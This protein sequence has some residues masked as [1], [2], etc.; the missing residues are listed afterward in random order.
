MDV[1]DEHI[2]RRAGL[3]VNS[4][5]ERFLFVWLLSAM[6]IGYVLSVHLSMLSGAIVALF[7]YMTFVTALGT[8]LRDFVYVFA[9]PQKLVVMFLLI[10]LVLPLLAF[11]VAH[12]WL[13]SE[14]MYMVGVVLGSSIPVGVT[15]IM[16]TGLAGGDLPLALAIVSVDTMLSP[17]TLPLTIR[18]IFGRAVGMPFWT[19]FWGL[20]WMVVIPTIAGM[21][22]NEWSRG[23]IKPLLQP[24]A[25]PTSK[26]SLL[27]VVAINVAIVAPE[28]THGGH[29]AMLLIT[30][31]IM[32]AM[33]YGVGYFVSRMMRAEN[34]TRVTMTY[35]VG[36]RNISAGI[37]IATHYF[38]HAVSIPVVFAMLFQQPLATL[39]HFLFSRAQ[40][41]HRQDTTEQLPTISAHS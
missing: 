26:L 25:G 36:M 4:V 19:L 10:H 35:N 3:Q 40:K 32:A 29:L 2:W 28:L 15:S 9:H 21:I 31:M 17:L 23:R 39:L 34:K 22:V 12:I 30:L 38:G 41:A 5:L 7:A 27:S 8:R 13:S 18:V 6:G 37:V 1:S 24:F 20:F 33:G 14:S 16:W 11:G